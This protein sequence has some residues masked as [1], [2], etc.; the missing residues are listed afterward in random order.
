MSPPEPSP[1]S[2]APFSEAAIEA[3]LSP[4]VRRLAAPTALSPLAYDLNAGVPD[5]PTL[6]AAGLLEAA[7]RA[8]Q[9]DPAG[10]LTYGGQQ[11]YEPLRAWIAAR[12]TREGGFAVA[13]DQ[14]TL[15]SGSAH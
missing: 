11:G 9:D 2:D 5:R 14:V 7:R 3:R 12:E 6:P 4:A 8:L 10:A 1:A 13:S 15:T